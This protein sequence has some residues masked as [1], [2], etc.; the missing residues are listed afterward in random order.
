MNIPVYSY[1]SEVTLT[2]SPFSER[3]YDWYGVICDTRY[4]TSFSL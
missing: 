3:T 2:S 4:L 1:P